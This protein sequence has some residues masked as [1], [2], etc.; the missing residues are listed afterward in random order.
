MR[1]KNICDKTLKKILV[2][3]N[4]NEA[5][6]IT[7][8]SG[9][10]MAPVV[11]QEER[12]M[13]F[14]FYKE[15]ML[16]IHDT[17]QTS[18]SIEQECVYLP[19]IFEDTIITDVPYFRES[20]LPV[21]NTQERYVGILWKEDL[22]HALQKHC[23]MSN[24]SFFD[25]LSDGVIIIEN[26]LIKYSNE[27]CCQILK[28]QKEEMI[29]GSFHTVLSGSPL[30][31]INDF[32]EAKVPIGNAIIAAKKILQPPMS[33]NDFLIILKDITFL[34]ECGDQ[35]VSR[36]G[37]TGL[38]LKAFEAASDGLSVMDAQGRVVQINK[39]HERILGFPSAE[40]VGKHVHTLIKEKI[41]SQ[42]VTMQV[43]AKR[44]TSTVHQITKTSSRVLTTGVPIF[45]SNGNLIYTVATSRDMRQLKIKEISGQYFRSKRKLFVAQD[46]HLSDIIEQLGRSGYVFQSPK[47]V[48]VIS[49]VAKAAD[50]DT[51]ILILGETGV[52]KDVI[53][54]TIHNLGP[55]RDNPFVPVNCAAI[56]KELI[57]SELFGYVK[58]AFT[59]A[60]KEGKR[61]LI[62]AANGGTLFLDE[63]A[64]LSQQCQVK[65]LRTL[66]DHTITRIGCTTPIRIK[67]RIIAATNRDLKVMITRGD[68]RE[69]FFFRLSV[70]PIIIPPLRERAEEIP[71][72]VHSYLDKFNK[73]YNKRIMFSKEAMSL[74]MLYHWPGNVREL[75]NM[76]ERCI[77]LSEDFIVKPE[78]LN[79][80]FSFDSKPSEDIKTLHHV[81]E[82][83]ERE[84]LMKAMARYGST[85]KVARV[86]GVSQPT[87]VRKIGKLF[88]DHH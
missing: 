8:F 57:E 50:S 14:F 79:L 28:T 16:L 40:V 39:A 37:L 49:T 27:K 56:P 6:C 87:V 9:K 73:K 53:A 36:H 78:D 80:E 10:D 85:Y 47:M 46:H 43:I 5:I 63:V 55:N 18:R 21:I 59:G 20:F 86:L 11:D 38:V 68:F 69:D 31:G 33:G 74:M 54:K 65:L 34:E 3:T 4:R 22:Y 30:I 83:A 41:I 66:Q 23:N 88:K 42:A 75:A 70:I 82:T 61:G 19:P 35:L 45:D 67:I 2:G 29:G 71:A 26:G 52:G 1:V 58:G 62:E 24:Y 32:Q 84:L 48:D 12:Y 76:I 44:A 72:L 60:K 17:K 15:D 64:E 51:A 81:L 77:V 13:G 7:Q 25:Y